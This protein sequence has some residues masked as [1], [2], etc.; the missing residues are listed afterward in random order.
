MISILTPEEAFLECPKLLRG[1]RIAKNMTQ[2]ELAQRSGV[3]VSVLR[4]FEQTGKIS[5]E[6]FIKLTF[7]LGL[8][9]KVIQA[10]QLKTEF[11]NMDELLKAEESKKYIAKSA[12]RSRKKGKPRG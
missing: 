9:D 6:S 4:K 10:L 1:H 8:T 11:S 5:F 12:T 2:A 7:V 3:S